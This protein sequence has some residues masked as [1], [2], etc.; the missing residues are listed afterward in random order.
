MSYS[1]MRIQHGSIGTHKMSAL[2]KITKIMKIKVCYLGFR[3]RTLAVWGSASQFHAPNVVKHTKTI[4][5]TESRCNSRIF[6]T[7]KI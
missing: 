6:E 4:N 1:L 3:A 5:K 7:I 2:K